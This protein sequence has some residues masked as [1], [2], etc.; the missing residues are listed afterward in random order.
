MS[1]F[2]KTK[3][4]FKLSKYRERMVRESPK[5][6]RNIAR[7]AVNHFVGGFRIGGHRTDESISGWKAREY[8]DVTKGGRLSRRKNTRGILVKSGKLRRSIGVI[9]ISRTANRMTITVGT[10]G[11]PYANIHNEGG[12]IRQR[13]TMKQIIW[14]YHAWQNTGLEVFKNAAHGAMLNIDIPQRQFIGHSKMLNRKAL[15]LIRRE[16]RA[17]VLK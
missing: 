12:H 2:K 11:I 17:K 4:S 3:G 13:M 8:P 10:K 9:S 1:F 7:E 6:A 5:L 14:F 16:M 15:V